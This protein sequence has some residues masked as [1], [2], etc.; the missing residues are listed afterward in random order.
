MAP[1]TQRRSQ[2]T[3]ALRS[4]PSSCRCRAV[5]PESR[6]FL[7]LCRPP[8]ERAA[9]ADEIGA[10]LGMRLEIEPPR[11]LAVGLTVHRHR[12]QVR[13]IIEMPRDHTPLLA[14]AAPG[15]REAH[16]PPP[17]ALRTPQSDPATRGAV[18]IAM[19]GP[20]QAYEPSRREPRSL[21][22]FIGHRSLL[23]G[24]PRSRL[25]ESPPRRSAPLVCT[26]ADH[27]AL[28]SSTSETDGG[29]VTGTG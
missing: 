17:V 26:G 18:Q 24:L 14:G 25:R 5:V 16:H 8:S 29:V 13:T 7:S 11:R 15:G 28:L 21:L 20:S 4:H 27:S 23:H 19:C 3:E 6:S 22:G 10:V 12:D 9:A 2:R 1:G